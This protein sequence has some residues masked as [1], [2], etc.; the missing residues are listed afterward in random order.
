MRAKLHGSFKGKY[1]PRLCIRIMKRYY[2]II[3]RYNWI[4]QRYFRER[5]HDTC[6]IQRSQRVNVAIYLTRDIRHSLHMRRTKYSLSRYN[7]NK[8]SNVSYNTHN[9]YIHKRL[10]QT[11]KYFWRLLRVYSK[12]SRFRGDFRELLG[13][14]RTRE[15]GKGCNRR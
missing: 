9:K 3:R 1:Y 15:R 10:A 11:C 12:R 7:A 8:I 4:F 6:A 2:Y 13:L 14:A 5:S